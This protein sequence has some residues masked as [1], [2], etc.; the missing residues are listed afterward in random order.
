MTKIKEKILIH[1]ESGNKTL[2]RSELL[3]QID[4]DR[5]RDTMLVAHEKNALLTIDGLFEQN[6]VIDSLKSQKDWNIIY[7]TQMNVELSNN[8]SKEKLLHVIEVMSYLREQGDQKFIPKQ[9]NKPVN[10][11]KKKKARTTG[12]RTEIVTNK[13]HIEK[14]LGIGLTT[15][16]G[17]VMGGG[18]AKGGLISAPV[19]KCAA[20]GGVVGAV[21]GITAVYI[22]HS[23]NKK[24][25]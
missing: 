24:Y 1:L 8:F 6:I 20:V 21:I 11:N 17:T 19:L 18:L 2:A 13:G 16:T 25:V 9:S 23:K 3:M 10:A 7:W 12:Q 15:L 5:F 4:A 14:A 22:I